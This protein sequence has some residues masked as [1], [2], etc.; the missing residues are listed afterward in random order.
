LLQLLES[1]PRGAKRAQGRG[2][3]EVEEGAHMYII[4]DSRP[5]FLTICSVIMPFQA[6]L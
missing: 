6:S 5:L 4:P 3:D 1:A 2:K